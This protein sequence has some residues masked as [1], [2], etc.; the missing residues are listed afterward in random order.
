MPEF[1]VWPVSHFPQ[2]LMWPRRWGL[3]LSVKNVF[4]S[5]FQVRFGLCSS[6]V[7]SRTDTATDSE[8]FYNS[9]LDLFEDPEEKDEVNDLLVWWNRW[10]FC[11]SSCVVIN[12]SISQIFPIYSNAQ[13]AVCKNSAL[14]RIKERRMTLRDL[15][16]W[17]C[18]Q[19]KCVHLMLNGI[20]CL[21]HASTLQRIYFQWSGCVLYGMIHGILLYKAWNAVVISD[22]L[23]I[24]GH[25]IHTITVVAWHKSRKA[26][27]NWFN[28]CRTDQACPAGY[29]NKQSKSCTSLPLI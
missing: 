25:V 21:P 15:N 4:L 2:S 9:V 12:M 24:I 29:P 1:M 5:F 11:S 16:W 14:A 6:P 28:R 23:G 20:P 10:G 26:L 22:N 13:R 17:T 7:F 8:R 18:R 19:L 27:G 3:I